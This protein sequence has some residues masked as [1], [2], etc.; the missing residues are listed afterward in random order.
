MF[1]R[2]ASLWCRLL[3]GLSR[4]GFVVHHGEEVTHVAFDFNVDFVCSPSVADV[5]FEGFNVVTHER[6]V[7]FD[8]FENRFMRNFHAQEL[9]DFWV[10]RNDSPL[11]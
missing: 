10:L 11:K 1:G 3:L 6:Y 4:S 5:G 7:F 2:H 9:S 8:P